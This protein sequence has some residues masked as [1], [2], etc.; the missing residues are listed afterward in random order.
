MRW[1]MSDI[2]NM[3]KHRSKDI[4]KCPKCNEI[5]KPYGENFNP[6]PVYQKHLTD[7]DREQHCPECGWG[8]GLVREIDES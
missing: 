4:W 5:Y 1:I 3:F 2:R 6:D 8:G 7:I